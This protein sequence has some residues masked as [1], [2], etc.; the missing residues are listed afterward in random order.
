MLLKI[1]S[2]L[3]LAASGRALPEVSARQDHIVQLES[4][5]LNNVIL[6]ISYHTRALLLKHNVC[7]A[8]LDF[9]ALLRASPTR[10]IP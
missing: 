2:Q 9:I 7:Y 5:H 4:V 3:F 10:M 6:G 8:L 1:W